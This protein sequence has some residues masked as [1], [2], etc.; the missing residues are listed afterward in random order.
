MNNFL[1]YFSFQ[2]TNTLAG[3]F[4]PFKRQSELEYGTYSSSSDS[5][6]KIQRE[7]KGKV[8]FQSYIT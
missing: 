4:T 1:K 7:E 6:K 8:V 5:E 3:N 2:V